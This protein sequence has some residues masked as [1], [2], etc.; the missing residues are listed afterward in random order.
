MKAIVRLLLA[1]TLVLATP[2][3]AREQTSLNSDWLFIKADGP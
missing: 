2:V 1:F 3:L